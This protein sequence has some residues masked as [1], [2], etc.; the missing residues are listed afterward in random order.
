MRPRPGANRYWCGRLPGHKGGT[1]QSGTT[2]AKEMLGEVRGDRAG[3]TPASAPEATQN[4]TTKA[5]RATE[6]WIGT[7]NRVPLWSVRRSIL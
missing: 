5:S 2:M 6:L 3:R 4:F 1:E 7:L